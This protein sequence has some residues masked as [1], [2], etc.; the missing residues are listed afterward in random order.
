VKI[1]KKELRALRHYR[2]N[3]DTAWRYVHGRTR[4]ALERKVLLRG[5]RRGGRILT[6]A[7]HAALAPPPGI[8][9]LFADLFPPKKAA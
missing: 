4:H 2:D 7:G 3:P 5:G 1:T 9:D 8:P 6:A